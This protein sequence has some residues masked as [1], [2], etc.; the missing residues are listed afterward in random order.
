MPW[1]ARANA[2]LNDDLRFRGDNLALAAVMLLAVGV[3][4][5][6]S[7][8]AFFHTPFNVRDPGGPVA[9]QTAVMMK[10]PAYFMLDD[11]QGVLDQ[12]PEDE[13]F[14]ASPQMG[15][16]FRR[17]LTWLTANEDPSLSTLLPEDDPARPHFE[18]DHL[19]ARLAERA[20][21]FIC[22][23]ALQL[24]FPEGWRGI[25]EE[26]LRRNRRLYVPVPGLPEAWLR[27]DLARE[28]LRSR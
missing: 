10:M 14:L 23:S 4:L 8:V 26:Y 9:R 2:K 22:L 6:L 13:R 17:G 19:R 27:S 21:A 24:N 12:V 7:T 28:S 3:G 15:L 18:A 5:L 16:I 11:L 20:P 1:A 25:V